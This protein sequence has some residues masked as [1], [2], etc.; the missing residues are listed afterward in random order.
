MK[1]YIITENAGRRVAGFRNTGVGTELSM[2]EEQAAAAI[3]AGELVL[4]P[5][6]DEVAFKSGRKRAPKAAAAG[7]A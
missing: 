4:R 7:E 1:T 3:E 2:P 5:G 6:Q